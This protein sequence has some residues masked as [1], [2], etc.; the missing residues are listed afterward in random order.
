MWK[1]AEVVV[2]RL[3][4]DSWEG[5]VRTH[6]PLPLFWCWKG[7]EDSADFNPAM[8]WSWTASQYVYC[9]SSPCSVY[10]HHIYR[11]R[12]ERPTTGSVH[13]LIL[14]SAKTSI[15]ICPGLR[16]KMKIEEEGGS[17]EIKHNTQAE[18][19]KMRFDWES[20]IKSSPWITADWWFGLPASEDWDRETTSLF[21]IFKTLGGRRCTFIYCLVV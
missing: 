4:K 21:W 11:V 9:D 3:K 14:P 10:P 12:G 19:R 5:E 18:Q 17:N 16:G 8:C 7:A 15:F 1:V 2:W 13:K 20:Q 6:L